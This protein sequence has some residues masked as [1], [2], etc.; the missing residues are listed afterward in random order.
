VV[1]KCTKKETVGN[2]VIIQIINEKHYHLFIRNNVHKLTENASGYGHLLQ[3][4]IYKEGNMLYPMAEEALS[5][6]QK[7]QVEELC[8]KININIFFNNNI[9]DLLK[10]IFQR[11]VK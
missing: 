4:H 10:I 11:H 1:R 6:N 7:N 2:Y 8:N 5:D 3:S 9:N